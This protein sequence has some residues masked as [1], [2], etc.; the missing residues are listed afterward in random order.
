MLG[1]LKRSF[2]QKSR[3]P[4][5]NMLQ[6]G[7]DSTSNGITTAFFRFLETLVIAFFSQNRPLPVPGNDSD[8]GLQTWYRKQ[9]HVAESQRKDAIGY[10]YEL[11]SNP[12][13]FHS[14]VHTAGEQIDEET[15]RLKHRLMSLDAASL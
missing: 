2:K 12:D 1:E 8:R 9:R 10:I 7:S 6:I 13:C 4:L 14:L 5:V 15:Y 11:R 3:R